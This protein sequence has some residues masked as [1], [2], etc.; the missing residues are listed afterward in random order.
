MF[1]TGAVRLANQFV[2]FTVLRYP[3][4][5]SS[6]AWGVAIGAAAILATLAARATTL[7]LEKTIRTGHSLAAFAAA[8]A[9]FEG[10]LFVIALVVLG[11]RRTSH[12]RSRFPADHT[13]IHAGTD[14]K[15]GFG[16]N[17]P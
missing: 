8:F 11:G 4:T 17:P 12:Q 14:R 2:G 13:W 6:F 16:A 7:G 5:I 10:V 3:L 9:V 1:L 15:G